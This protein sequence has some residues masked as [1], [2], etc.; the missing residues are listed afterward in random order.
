ML[1]DKITEEIINAAFTAEKPTVHADRNEFTKEYLEPTDV[2]D[3]GDNII[4]LEDRGLC[5]SL[6]L[7]HKVVFV[8]LV[9]PDGKILIAEK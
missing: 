3:E 5:H 6:G 2:I 4:G 8:F 7:R 9:S 1:T